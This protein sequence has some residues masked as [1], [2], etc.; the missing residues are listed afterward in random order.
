MDTDNNDMCVIDVVSTMTM[1]QFENTIDYFLKRDRYIK[2]SK[3][4]NYQLFKMIN[5]RKLDIQFNLIEITISKNN[6]EYM[7]CM[8]YKPNPIYNIVLAKY[9]NTQNKLPAIFD[10]FDKLNY[11]Y[12]IAK[13]VTSKLLIQTFNDIIKYNLE[14]NT[15]RKNTNLLINLLSLTHR[16]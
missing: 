2:K 6:F 8:R 16:V 12:E 4:T 5:K 11:E 15:R 3:I 10:E 1:M 14:N 9:L 13:F 7:I